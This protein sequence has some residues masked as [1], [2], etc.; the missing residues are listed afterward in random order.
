M[1][2][3]YIVYANAFCVQVATLLQYV[4]SS[5]YGDISHT[6]KCVDVIYDINTLEAIWTTFQ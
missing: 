4:S 1:F 3:T 5:F 6:D 2:S